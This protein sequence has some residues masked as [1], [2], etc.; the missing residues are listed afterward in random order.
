[1]TSTKFSVSWVS[2]WRIIYYSS[3]ILHLL[4]LICPIF[5]CVDP[6][7]YSEYR[8]RSTRL[9]NTDPI[10]IWIH[11]NDAASAAPPRFIKR[12]RSANPDFIAVCCIVYISTVGVY[13][14]L[15]LAALQAGTYSIGKGAEGEGSNDFMVVTSQSSPACQQ[16]CTANL[17]EEENN[18]TQHKH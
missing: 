5:T 11:K 6:D 9:S 17:G 10:W 8:S 15:S 16:Y 12:T 13:F 7:P 18:R 1:M 3:T 4:P 14:F 2:E